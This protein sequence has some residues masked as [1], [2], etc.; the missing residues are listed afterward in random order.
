MKKYDDI[1]KAFVVIIYSEQYIIDASSITTVCYKGLFGLFLFAGK[2]L[3]K[4]LLEDTAVSL[5]T[6]ETL[7]TL[8]GSYW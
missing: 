5:Y 1:L 2:Q 3:V 6:R 4:F 7:E 8:L